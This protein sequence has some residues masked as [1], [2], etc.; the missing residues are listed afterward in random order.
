MKN[1]PQEYAEMLLDKY[2]ESTEHLKEGKL[3][4]KCAII[5]VNNTL[6]AIKIFNIEA[7]NV[8][9]NEVLT[10]LKSKLN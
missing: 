2:E 7:V 8:Y 10:I 5:D 9:Y 1:S 4:K 3:V 6:K